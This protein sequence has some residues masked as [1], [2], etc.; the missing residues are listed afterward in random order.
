MC[1]KYHYHLNLVSS[2]VELQ[3]YYALLSVILRYANPASGSGDV[4][5]G[6]A[7]YLGDNYQQADER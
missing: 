3:A 6:G 1:V 5:C 7:S 4:V 2:C